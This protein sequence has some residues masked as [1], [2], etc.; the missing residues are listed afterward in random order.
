ME[1]TMT[2][3]ATLMGLNHLSSSAESCVEMGDN[4]ET[5]TLFLSQSAGKSPILEGRIFIIQH[6]VNVRFSVDTC[7][8]FPVCSRTNNGS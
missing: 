2:A 4:Y 7:G 1:I 6:V 8:S 5:I 3:A